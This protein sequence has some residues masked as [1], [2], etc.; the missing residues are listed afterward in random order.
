[1]IHSWGV[2]QSVTDSRLDVTYGVKMAPHVWLKEE[3]FPSWHLYIMIL[4][5][6]P[7]QSWNIR[8]KVSLKLQLQ[9][10]MK[11]TTNSWV[12]FVKL[13]QVLQLVVKEWCQQVT[14]GTKQQQTDAVPV[15][16]AQ[17]V[18]KTHTLNV[19]QGPAWIVY[20][21]NWLTIRHGSFFQTGLHPPRPPTERRRC[22]IAAAAS[23][24]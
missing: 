7:P 14:S 23:Q 1:M 10:S 5:L 13:L 20:E 24:K 17:G 6:R 9:H 18:K 15:K 21:L 16:A 11:K 8:D 22:F 12:F 19:V 3:T 2:C 4:S